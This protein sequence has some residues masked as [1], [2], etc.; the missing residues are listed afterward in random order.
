MWAFISQLGFRQVNTSSLFIIWWHKSHMRRD[1]DEDDEVGSF[2]GDEIFFDI[3]RPSAI[4]IWVGGESRGSNSTLY[5][6]TSHWIV[7]P[8]LFQGPTRNIWDKTRIRYRK[9]VSFDFF[10]STSC[11]R[12]RD[13]SGC[14]HAH[15]N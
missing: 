5:F 9:P 7:K 2:D 12:R 13:F 1:C 3:T 6:G 15:S 11:L 14:C 10:R 8:N 4:G